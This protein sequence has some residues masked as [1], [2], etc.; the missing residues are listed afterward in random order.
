MHLSDISLP[1][2][3]IKFLIQFKATSFLAF[4]IE[5]LSPLTVHRILQNFVKPQDSAKSVVH[6]FVFGSP[7]PTRTDTIC[8]AALLCFGGNFSYS[9]CVSFLCFF[10]LC[11]T[12]STTA[13]DA[14]LH[15]SHHLSQQTY[16]RHLKQLY[17]LKPFFFT[18]HIQS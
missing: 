12:V 2:Y 15:I 9:L 4:T 3:C 16:L 6:H 1:K 13:H 10:R 11:P 14:L 8:R 17:F 5:V 18:L 7:V